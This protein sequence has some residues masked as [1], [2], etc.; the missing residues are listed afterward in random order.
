MGTFRGVAA[1]VAAGV[2]LSGCGAGQGGDE[3]TT[4]SPIVTETSANPWDLPIEQRPA[5][6][7]PCAEIPIE[8]VEQAV[9]GPVEPDE[10]LTNR[11]PGELVTCGW[12]NS[13][14]MINTI[15]TW[16]S[17]EGYLADPSFFLRRQDSAI[18][19]RRGLT[20]VEAGDRTDSTCL[21]LFFTGRGTAYIKLDLIDGLS[22]F[23]GQ[24]FTKACDVLDEAIVPLLPYIPEGDFS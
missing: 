6:F 16:K 14:V 7:D 8:A 2:L 9:G 23:R 21:Q 17:R 24:R 4:T 18:L 22:E 5:L 13:E 20:M 1:A 19:G 11:R 12:A 15:G 3:T 10:R